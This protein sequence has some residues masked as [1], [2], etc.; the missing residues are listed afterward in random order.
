MR[1]AG[2]RAQDECEKVLERRRVVE[3]RGYRVADAGQ[4]S[5]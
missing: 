3:N 4:A 5:S 1:R 2:I